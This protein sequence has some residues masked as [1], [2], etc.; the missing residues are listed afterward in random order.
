MLKLMPVLVDLSSYVSENWGRRCSKSEE[1]SF[2]EN[3]PIPLLLGLS[4]IQIKVE[5]GP[6][7]SAR[8]KIPRKTSPNMKSR[9]LNLNHH[10]SQE[11][12]I[13]ISHVV[14]LLNIP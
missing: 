11:S 1:R 4:W 5:P 12:R 13:S 6:V 9:I 3:Q 8:W 2:D 7:A 14:G 10:A